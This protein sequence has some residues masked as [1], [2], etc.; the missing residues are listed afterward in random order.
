MRREYVAAFVAQ[1]V[2]RRCVLELRD[3]IRWRRASGR[4]CSG[5]DY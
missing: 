5:H 2:L 4:L 1:A 3:G